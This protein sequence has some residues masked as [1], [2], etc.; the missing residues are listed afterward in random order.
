MLV[1]VDLGGEAVRA[2][3]KKRSSSRSGEFYRRKWK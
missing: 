3:S 1:E 2:E